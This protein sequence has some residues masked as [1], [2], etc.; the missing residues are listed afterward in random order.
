LTM[1]SGI[2]KLRP[3]S[4]AV[5]QDGKLTV[6]RYWKTV[7]PPVADTRSDGELARELW[8]RVTEATDARLMADVPV[9]VFLSGGLDSS[10]IAAQM[11]DLRK[12]RG[13]GGVKSFSVGY[14]AED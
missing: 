13:E 14:L 4:C 9:G 10:C 2:E 3:G 6:R 5:F 8:K 7:F 12:Q 1:F 11:I